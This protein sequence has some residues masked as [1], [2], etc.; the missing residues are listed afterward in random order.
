MAR[1]WSRVGV[2]PLSSEVVVTASDVA[3]VANP[4]DRSIAVAPDARY[5]VATPAG[6]N[7]VVSP[8]D[9]YAV[10]S[11]PGPQGPPG[12][13]GPTGAPGG[14]RYNHEQATPAT[15]WVVQHN[16]GYEP[17]FTTVIVEGT[18][19]TDGVDIFHIDANNMTIR[20]SQAVTGKAAVL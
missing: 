5:A 8:V 20:F 2:V 7:S 1:W 17:L 13:T 19:V 18:D 6:A 3:V 15:V 16:L 10:V 11:A 12:P 14:S 4:A 9:R